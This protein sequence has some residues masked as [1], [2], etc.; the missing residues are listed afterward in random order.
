MNYKRFF[1]IVSLF[2]VGRSFA[3][4]YEV[5]VLRKWD[6]AHK[7]YH[8]FIGCSDFHDKTHQSNGD[9]LK[10]IESLLAKCDRNITKVM[11]EDLSSPN[12]KGRL[13]C[14]RFV[15]NSRG[16]ILGGLAEKGRSLGL[17][18]NNIEF[19]YCRVTS[20]GPVLNNLKTDME[21][22]PSVRSISMAHLVKEVQET[23]SE[24]RS[25]NDGIALK[26]IYD[27]T[28]KDVSGY[29]SS[30]HMEKHQDMN[31]SSY[32]KAHSHENNRLD[33]LKK[34]LT[35]DSGLLDLR[36]LHGVVTGVDK[37][38]VIAIAGG[39]HISRACE[40]LEKVGYQQMQTTKVNFTK[41]HD[42]KKCLGSHI[43]DGNFCVKPEPISLDFLEPLVLNK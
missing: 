1:L 38:K 43:V 2:V 26:K 42:L 37:S 20:L 40:L 35:F 34:L 13:A 9:Q 23:I 7:R 24:V 6:A 25:Y 36:M 22:F 21:T 18:I 31:V 41:E 29:L 33:L 32:L 5:K 12:N 16:G 8:Y 17:D 19:R 11:L 3:F 14:G 28:I 39:A 27:D 30:L 15:V 4:I 10:K